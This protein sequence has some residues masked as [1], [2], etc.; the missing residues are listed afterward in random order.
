M[1]SNA[2]KKYIELISGLLLILI[3]LLCNE[4]FLAKF[5]TT[6]SKITTTFYRVIIWSYDILF[7]LT[8]L[9]M[10]FSKKL[11]SIRELCLNLLLL[12]TSIFTIFLVFELLFPFI[13]PYL[14]LN[15]QTYVDPTFRILCQS[16]KKGLIPKNYIA[17][18]GDSYAEGIGD[19]LIKSTNKWKNGKFHSAHL[20][21]NALDTDVISIAEGGTGSIH[22]VI[23]SVIRLHILKQIFKLEDPRTVLVY[24]YEGNDLHDNSFLTLKDYEYFKDIKEVKMLKKEEF[25]HALQATIKSHIYTPKIHLTA[26]SFFLVY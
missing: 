20:I 10:I 12:A 13:L 21:N 11:N 26:T 5:L 23:S 18:L 14:P 6:D 1:N 19:W 16:S 25:N 24:F 3:G 17:I 15:L 8:G 7:I 9:L 4:W 2:T 22:P